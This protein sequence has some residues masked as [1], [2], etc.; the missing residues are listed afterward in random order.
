[1]GPQ[2]KDYYEAMKLGLQFGQEAI[3]EGMITKRRWVFLLIV[4]KVLHFLLLPLS[5]YL[6]LTLKSK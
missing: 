4:E 3:E 5:I 1:M 2:V 6:I